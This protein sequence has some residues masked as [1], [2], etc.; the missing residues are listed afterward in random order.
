MKTSDYRGIMYNFNS[1]LFKD[2]KELPNALSYA[3]DRKAILDSVL[4][5]HGKV[6]YSP[7]QTG[8]YNNPDMEKFDYNPTKAKQD[9]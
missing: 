7:L 8:E 4:L 9:A 6:A 3:I 5:G 1:P 2:N